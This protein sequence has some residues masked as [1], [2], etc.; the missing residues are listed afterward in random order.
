MPE[1]RTT[2]EERTHVINPQAW[3]TAV[4]ESEALSKEL[5]VKVRDLRILNYDQPWEVGDQFLL[6]DAEQLRPYDSGGAPIGCLRGNLFAIGYPSSVP[7]NSVSLV[8]SRL[9]DALNKLARAQTVQCPSTWPE[10]MFEDYLKA[11]GGH[12]LGVSALLIDEIEPHDLDVRA[13]L[14]FARG[15]SNRETGYHLVHNHGMRV[16]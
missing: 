2:F 1:L 5:V 8:A 14:Q 15:L 9:Y 4:Y 3:E 13:L 11:R 10:S 6:E 7:T 12:A 16:D